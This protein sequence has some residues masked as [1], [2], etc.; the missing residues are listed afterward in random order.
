M[1]F[2]EEAEQRVED[3]PKQQIAQ[4]NPANNIIDIFNNFTLIHFLF[5]ML[6]KM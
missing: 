4:W 2:V 6:L 5:L 1:Y 3:F